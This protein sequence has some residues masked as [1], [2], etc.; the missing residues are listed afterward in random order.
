MLLNSSVEH[1]SLSALMISWLSKAVRRMWGF[2]RFSHPLLVLYTCIVAQQSCA[3]GA[4]C[5]GG[6][7]D[8]GGLEPGHMDAGGHHCG[9]G[10]QAGR[11][12]CRVLL[13]LRTGQVS[14]LP[15]MKC[16]IACPTLCQKP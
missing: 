15:T 5:G 2:K 10:G 7:Q 16:K 9:D 6:A 4:G 1:L 8:R 12:L 3:L 13:K 14:T 11:Q